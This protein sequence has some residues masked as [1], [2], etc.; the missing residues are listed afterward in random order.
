MLLQI[1]RGEP[2]LRTANG[3][4][5][6]FLELS[7]DILLHISTLQD[8]LHSQDLMETAEILSTAW[9]LSGVAFPI[10]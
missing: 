6:R 8:F 9:L 5:I 3:F 1:T 7:S 10:T 4:G 2:S